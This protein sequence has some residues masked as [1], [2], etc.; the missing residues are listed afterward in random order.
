MS[1]PFF[2]SFF[3]FFL[4]LVL[5][6]LSTALEDLIPSEWDCWCC[7]MKMGRWRKPCQ[8][9]VI[10]SHIYSDSLLRLLTLAPP[11]P[12]SALLFL[13]PLATA[14]SLAHPGRTSAAAGGNWQKSKRG[15]PADMEPEIMKPDRCDGASRENFNLCLIIFPS[16]NFTA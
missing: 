15:S 10:F 11:L 1:N 4:V 14:T 3:P 12:G 8:P 9:A 16:H 6:L 13:W 5:L 7:G 2:L